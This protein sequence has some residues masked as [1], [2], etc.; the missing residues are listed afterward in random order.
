MLY[1]LMGI[2][3]S[4]N[5]LSVGI[6]VKDVLYKTGK[7]I[8][9]NRGVIRNISLVGLE[10]LSTIIKK[11]QKNHYRGYRFVMLFDASSGVQSEIMRTLKRDPRIIKTSVTNINTEKK[12]DIAT[13][14]DRVR[15]YESILDKVRSSKNV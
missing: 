14:I 4:T 13:S 2:V 11:D 12:L 1:E 3:R 15:G 9:N 5:K 7:L 8:I 10:Q 6:E